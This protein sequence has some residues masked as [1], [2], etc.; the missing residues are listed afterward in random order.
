M[1]YASERLVAACATA[2]PHAKADDAETLR[3][4][5]REGSVS[6]A[7]A[8]LLS[9]LLRSSGAPGP[10]WVHELLQGAEPQL[11]KRAPKAPAHPDL[12]PRLARLRAAQADREYARMVGQ[13]VTDDSAC[14]DAAEMSTYRSQMGVR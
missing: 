7:E 1:R 4:C 2:L 11:P 6:L 12:E 9:S 14:R 10:S 5:Q 3:R 13:V 8:R